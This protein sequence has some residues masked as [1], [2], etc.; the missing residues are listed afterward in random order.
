L[1]AP[2][3]RHL[4]LLHPFLVGIYFVLT[5]AAANAQ[6]LHG[7]RELLVPLG[8]CL[9]FCAVCWLIAFAFTRHSD[10]AA[11]MSLLWVFAFS[12][13]GYVAESL[14]SGGLLRR[15]GGEPALVGLFFLA[16]WGPSLAIRRTGLRLEPLHHYL[17]LVSV[18]LIG[19]AGLKTY[20]GME[21]QPEPAVALQ[22][23][24]ISV[25]RRTQDELPDIYLIVL[26]KYTNGA[27]LADHF[28]FDNSHFENFLRSRGFV[29]PRNPRANYPRT[30]LA[31]A[32][33]LN[34]DYI[35][36]L[37]RPQ[38]QADPIEHNR[39][40]VFLK[41]EG[42]RFVFL[43]TAFKFTSKNRY[44]DLQLPPPREVVGEFRAAWERTTM[45]PEVIHAGCAVLRC[46]AARF[47]LLPETAE[48]LD[49]KFERMGELAGG[50]QPTFVFAHLM[51]PHEPFLYHADCSYREPYWPAKAGLLGDEEATRGYLD[52]ISCANRKVSELVDTILTRSRRPSVILLQS[53]HGHGR[54][55]RIPALKYVKPTQ[56]KER[57]ASFAAYLVPGLEPERITDSITPVNVMRVLLSY[58]FG[59]DLPLLED[60]SYWSSEDKPLEFVRIDWSQSQQR[61]PGSDARG[62]SRKRD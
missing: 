36:N 17:T 59:A 18:I 12:V 4:W 49:W 26:D 32:S 45:L 11:L 54:I 1:A 25:D 28:G 55:E 16:V 42:Y 29:V 52:Q 7:W 22:L 37:P 53:D 3:V 57:M 46:Q 51:F 38:L 61:I 19:Y 44:A 24:A 14:R 58:Y 34:L 27:L 31:L 56:V 43:P 35:H 15:A 47:R 48:L 2:R 23:P 6:A 9:G 5:L 41:R 33:M 21:R 20:R 10:K 13:F 8:I 62:V 50:Q 60:A 39:M 30:Q 40:A